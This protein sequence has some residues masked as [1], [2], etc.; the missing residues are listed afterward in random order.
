MHKNI[1]SAFAAIARYDF[2]LPQDQGYAFIDVPLSIGYGQTISQPSTVAWM[3]EQ[4]EIEEGQHVLDV[5][6]GSG[7]TTA[8]L[9]FLVGTHGSVIGIERIPELVDFGKKNL[10]KYHLV[11]ASILQSLPNTLGYPSEAPYDCILVSAA[12]EQVPKKLVEQLKIDGIMLIPLH[13][14]ICKVRKTSATHY[15]S[16]KYEGYAF[17]PL[18][19]PTEAF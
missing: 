9:A 7:W 3:L 18:I 11:Q 6:S 13:S 4:L 12:A 19:S 14:A 17:V 2:V 8:L 5:G 16:E 10:S 15:K 1:E